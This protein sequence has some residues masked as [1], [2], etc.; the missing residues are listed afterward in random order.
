MVLDGT[1]SVWSG[2]GWY[3]VILG[4]Y[5]AVLVGTWWYWVSMGQY[6]LLL[7][8]TE[9]VGIARCNLKWSYDQTVWLVWL[10]SNGK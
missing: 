4:Q 9:T 7:G 2:T 10:E 3:L 6:C 5:G 1:G 8:G